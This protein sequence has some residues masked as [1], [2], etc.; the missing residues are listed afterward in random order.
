[1]RQKKD[2]KQFLKDRTMVI[3]PVASCV[4][5]GVIAFI[6]GDKVG[7]HT[8]ESDCNRLWNEACEAA[9]VDRMTLYNATVEKWTEVRN[10]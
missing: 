8:G 7:R 4:T 3:V 2:I 6:I 9:G 1:M 5:I 10:S